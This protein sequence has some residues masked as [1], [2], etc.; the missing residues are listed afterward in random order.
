[1]ACG[2][3]PAVSRAGTGGGR[4]TA[5]AA[6]QGVPLQAGT[7][8]RGGGGVARAGSPGGVVPASAPG[9]GMATGPCVDKASAPG[10]REDAVAC[11]GR[12]GCPAS[13]PSSGAHATRQCGSVWQPLGCQTSGARK[14]GRSQRGSPGI[15]RVSVAPAGGAGTTGAAT[16]AAW[17]ADLGTR[18]RSTHPPPRSSPSPRRRPVPQRR[19]VRRCRLRRCS[20]RGLT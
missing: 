6:G 9:I 15:A 20:K 10:L 7:D 18:R 5:G 8:R 16:T 17:G 14:T 3:C 4:R 19:R 12:R 13:K 11:Q 1:M 2:F